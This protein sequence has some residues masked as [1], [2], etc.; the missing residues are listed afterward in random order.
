LERVRYTKKGV[1]CQEEKPPRF[2]E[3]NL[4]GT[5]PVRRSMGF[6]KAKYLAKPLSGYRVEKAEGM[7]FKWQ[8]FEGS[9]D[10]RVQFRQSEVWQ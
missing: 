2:Q 5:I 6:S 8:L 7:I 4:Y 3:K 1:V 9:R 10:Q